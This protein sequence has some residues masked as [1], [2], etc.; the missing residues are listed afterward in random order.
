[1]KK[2]LPFLL[3]VSLFISCKKEAV[4]V[5]EDLIVQAMINGQWVVTSFTQNGNN[6]TSN[7]SGYKFQ[8][9]S[10]RT[11]DAIKNGVKEKTGNWGGSTVTMTTWVDFTAAPAPLILINGT[12]NVIDTGFDYL[13]ATQTNGTEIKTLRLEKK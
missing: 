1:M 4:A 8:F 7:F 13:E 3:G 10:N 9:Y 6:I 2:I 11:V 12:W 5:A